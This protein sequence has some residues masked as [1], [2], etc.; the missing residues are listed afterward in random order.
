MRLRA[1]VLSI[2]GALALAAPSVASAAKPVTVTITHMECVD[3]CDATG[4]EAA[5]ESTADLYA[6]VYID[7]VSQD[8]PYVND[9]PSVSPYYQVTRQVPDGE[10]QVP[11]AIQVWDQDSSSGDDL[12]DASPNSGDNNLDLTLNYDSGQWTSSDGAAFPETCSTGGGGDEPRIKVCFDLATANGG[13]FDGDGIPDSIERFGMPDSSGNLVPIAGGQMDPCRKTIAMQIDWMTDGTHSHRPTDAAVA[14][15]VAAMNAAPVPATPNCPYAG[16]PQ[17]ASGVNL[18]LDRVNQIPEQAVFGLDKLPAVRDGGNFPAARRPYM[19]YVIFVHD[20]AKGSSSSGLCCDSTKD[21]IVSLGSWANQVGTFRDQ[22]GSIL[23]EGGHSLGLGHGGNVGTNYKPNYLSVMNY[24]FDPTGIP[25]STIPANIDTDNNGTPDQSYRLD[26]SRSKL[27]DLNEAALNEGAGIGGLATDSTTW[28]DPA[29]AQKNGAASGALDWNST[30]PGNQNPVKV[31]LNR[32]YCIDAGKDGA[33]DSLPGGD[34][35]VTAGVILSGPNFICETTAANDD[36]QNTGSGT[37]VL[38]TLTGFDDWQ[39]IQYRAAM[40]PTAGGA[41]ATHPCCDITFEQAQQIESATAATYSPDLALAKSIDKPDAVQGDTLNYTLTTTNVGTGDAKAVSLTDTNLATPASLGVVA[42]GATVVRHDTFA[43]SCTTPDGTVITDNASVSGTNLLNNP[44]VNTT[45][46][47]ATASS[48]IHAPNVTLGKTATA[49]VAA[50][51][52]IHYRLTYANTGSGNA[53]SVT[54]TDTLPAGVYYSTALD[55]GA[56]P[57][58]TTVTHNADGTTTLTWSIGTVG[59]A[60]GTQAIEYTARPTLLMLPGTAI[61][62]AA[63]LTYTNANGCTYTPATASAGTA[64]TAVTATRNPL[65]HGYW[66][67]HPAEWTE[68][69]LARIQATD[70]RFDGIDLSA[71]DGRLSGNEV[72]TTLNATGPAE[73]VL[74]SQ[75][76]ATYFDLATRRINANTVISSKV[77]KKLGLA[78]VGDAARYAMQTLALPAASNKARYSDITTVLDGIVTNAIEV[79]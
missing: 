54:I 42:A 76:L 39:N 36:T 77:A 56:G 37:N 14:D 70:Q 43:V 22:A 5:L 20:Q 47:T 3:D 75:L 18:V 55:L 27:P 17:R 24:S 33:L 34:D 28:W 29:F 32:D 35:T 31:D 53:S 65:S 10:T 69:I 58:P 66:A 59:S 40:S 51:E 62:N 12:G 49:A 48:M 45:N 61:T 25:D 21:F 68:E 9:N 11:I 15:A 67:A 16:F 30:A 71:A 8:T 64:I 44:E 6:R 79:Y 7:G 26:Y 73:P 4:L 13:D 1:V 41:P 23:H 50:G 52:A 74:R 72:R 19:H 63:R 46:N 2:A 57:K 60:S 38:S 78:T